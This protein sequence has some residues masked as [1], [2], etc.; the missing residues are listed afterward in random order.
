MI[1]KITLVFL[2]LWINTAELDIFVWLTSKRS[3]LS[4]SSPEKFI[5]AS[6]T[7]KWSVIGH[8][9]WKSA[10]FTGSSFKEVLWLANFASKRGVCFWGWLINRAI[11]NQWKAFQIIIR[12]NKSNLTRSAWIHLFVIDLTFINSN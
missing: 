2:S 12:Q 9:V 5:I 6:S 10:Y 11:L 7:N 4:W 3:I 1:T 8:T